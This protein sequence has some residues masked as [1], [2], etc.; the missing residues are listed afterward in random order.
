MASN[1]TEMKYYR[2]AP[3]EV[4]FWRYVE[5][6]M[7]D[8]GCWEWA[9]GLRNHYGLFRH[10]LT[11]YAHRASW[12]ISFGEIPEGLDVCHHCDNP[13]CVNPAHLF[14][15]THQENVTDCVRKGRRAPTHGEFAGRHILTFEQVSS[16]RDRVARGEVQRHL[17][18]EY[19]VS[20]STVSAIIKGRL[21][22]KG[23]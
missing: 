6:M 7:D 13:S 9:G 19:S 18:R 3:P 5:P 10:P 17:A 14:L 22:S 15:G 4:R 12:V 11:R 21:W 1:T 23:K 2:C 8:R 16:I 20:V